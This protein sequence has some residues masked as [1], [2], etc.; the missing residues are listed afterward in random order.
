MTEQKVDKTPKMEIVD[1][2]P[3][4]TRKRG[5]SKYVPIVQEFH[6]SGAAAAKIIVEGVENQAISSGLKTALKTLELQEVIGVTSRTAGV[7]LERL[8][9]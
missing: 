1:A 5:Q 3:P 2:V 4:S 8:K 6:D 7:Y 9:K